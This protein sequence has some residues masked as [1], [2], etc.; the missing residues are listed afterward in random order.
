MCAERRCSVLG[1]RTTTIVRCGENEQWGMRS[2][3]RAAPPPTRAG[4]R[5]TLGDG[6]Q[7]SDILFKGRQLSGN[8]D[9]TPRI[10]TSPRS[11]M[12]L[13]RYSTTR[14]NHANMIVGCWDSPCSDGKPDA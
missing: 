13:V 2:M 4:T 5:L 3:A 12:W 7:L 8:A 14:A 6:D 10:D 9:S 11:S 1:R